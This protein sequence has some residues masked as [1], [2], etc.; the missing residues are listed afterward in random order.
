VSDYPSPE[1]LVQ[2]LRR[3]GHRTTKS[4]GQHF[5]TDPGILGA[6]VDALELTPATLAV[7]IGPGPGT[8]TTLLAGRA[9][10]VVAIE[11]D[12]RLKDF[13][14]RIF[15]GKRNVELIYEDALRVD[16]AALVAS[17]RELWT[18]KD[19]V[20]TGNLPYQITS[21]LLF[22]Q[23]GPDP[24]WRRIVVM[25]QKEVADRI[26]APPHTRAYGI[27]T[28]KLAYWW[29][30]RRIVDVP[31][32]LFSPPP[33]VDGTVLALVPRPFA[34]VPDPGEWKALSR[35]VDLCFNQRRKKLYNS[36]AVASLGAGGID[37]AKHAL[38]S[39]GLDA[40]VR[41]E[42]L[43]PDEFLRLFRALQ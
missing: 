7:E 5:M 35:F 28:V 33:K 41:A 25:I 31:A 15:S 18:L 6:L 40:N 39:L 43:S 13:H 27:L 23:V 20:L 37:R 29:E 1:L 9:G 21:P 19:A 38:E 10:G 2:L 11:R 22:G 14:D 3:S 12:T 36:P 16:L 32:A 26:L 4:L 17:H 42:D 34:S 30:P 8:L 24:L